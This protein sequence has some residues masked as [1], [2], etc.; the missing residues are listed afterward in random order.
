MLAGIPGMA[1]SAPVTNTFIATVAEGPLAGQ[2]GTGS[3]TY[4]DDLIIN[5]EEELNPTDGLLVTFSFDGQAFDQTN[6]VDFDDFP[7]L[8]F[9][10][11]IPIILDYFLVDGENG[12]N[13]NNPF[14]AELE[15]F[16][17]FPSSGNYDFEMEI[18]ATLVPIPGALWLFGSGL[19]GLVALRMRRRYNE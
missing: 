15:M 17:L 11:F 5:G 13:F 12:V 4:N 3:F 18:S 8:E 16:D 7:I 6:D 10:N 14:L 19:S 9:S 1:Q 2:S